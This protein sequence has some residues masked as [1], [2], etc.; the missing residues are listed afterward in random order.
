MSSR[1]A[2]RR[3]QHQEFPIFP[4]AT[5]VFSYAAEN[6]KTEVPIAAES[7]ATTPTHSRGAVKFPTPGTG[8]P[9]PKGAPEPRGDTRPLTEYGH[10]TPSDQAKHAYLTQKTQD[11]NRRL[12]AELTGMHVKYRATPRQTPPDGIIRRCVNDL[13]TGRINFVIA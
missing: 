2:G 6:K 3:L 4:G 5:W 7:A 1:A 9:R 10:N 8:M 11:S 13:T 12:T